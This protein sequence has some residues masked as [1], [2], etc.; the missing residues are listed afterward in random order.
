ML[1]SYPT[2]RKASIRYRGTTEIGFGDGKVLYCVAVDVI[3]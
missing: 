3:P 1:G 2:H